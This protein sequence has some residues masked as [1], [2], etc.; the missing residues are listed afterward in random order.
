MKSSR[1]KVASCIVI[2]SFVS[3]GV[4]GALVGDPKSDVV[5]KH[6]EG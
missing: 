1:L 6:Q 3:L 2:G 4:I 5:P